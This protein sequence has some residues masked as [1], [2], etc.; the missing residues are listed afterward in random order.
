MLC[1]EGPLD[2]IIAR[3]LNFLLYV[4]FQILFFTFEWSY[5]KNSVRL[6]LTHN[7]LIKF[8]VA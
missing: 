1:Y 5:Y 3:F 7:Y 2:I 6:Y 4:I 8:R